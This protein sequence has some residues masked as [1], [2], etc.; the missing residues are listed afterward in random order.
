VKDICGSQED[1]AGFGA[2]P[3]WSPVSCQRTVVWF[4]TID[5][6]L[7]ATLTRIDASLQHAGMRPVGTAINQLYAIGHARMP[8]LNSAYGG[9]GDGNLT[10]DITVDAPPDLREAVTQ[11]PDLLISASPPAGISATVERA[12]TPVQERD[13]TTRVKPPTYVLGLRISVPYFQQP[14]PAPSAAD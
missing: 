6:P 13:L 5:G 11:D 14:S 3:T 7:A 12:Y 2:R 8:Q 9:Y 4:G 1:A 10:V